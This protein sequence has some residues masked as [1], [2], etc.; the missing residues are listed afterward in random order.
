[1]GSVGR[2]IKVLWGHRAGLL[3]PT[4][5]NSMEGEWGAER[6]WGRGEV[7]LRSL[8]KCALQRGVG[9]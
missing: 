6:D 7:S 3:Y 2:R 8:D 1:M 9:H 5:I 4:T